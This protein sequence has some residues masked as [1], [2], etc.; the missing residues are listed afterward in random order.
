VHE[1]SVVQALLD[2]VAHHALARRATAVRG[3]TVRLGQLSGVEPDLLAT[4]F[5][6]AREGTL[7]SAAELVIERVPARWQCPRCESAIPEGNALVCSPCRASAVLVTGEELE[8]S[9]LELEIPRDV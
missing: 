5:E 1:F 8:L 4:A 9:S 7:A 3:I 2:Q 6:V